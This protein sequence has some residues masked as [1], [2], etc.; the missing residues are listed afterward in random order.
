MS[1]LEIVAFDL[2]T[3]GF[4]VSDEVTV[5][6]FA[7]PLGARVFLR[8]DDR[9]AGAV[10]STVRERADC[11]VHLST[12]GSERAVLEAVG[13]FAAARLVE[14][15]VLLVAYNGETWRSGFDLPFLRTRLARL[16]VAWPFRDMPYADLLPL[17]TKRFNTTIE[18]DADAQRDLAGVYA[19]LCEGSAGAMD[20]FEESSE[21]VTAFETGAFAELVLHNVA[22]VMR[23]RALGLLAERYCSKSDFELK[24]LT[25][26]RAD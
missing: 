2:E 23:T 4:T 22:D 25:P 6:G 13:E 20:P 18:A 8:T 21:A 1:E 9:A 14:D 16:D 19:T 11:H 3:T 17:V 15:E 5:V 7:F 12:H 24:S 26:T 10:E